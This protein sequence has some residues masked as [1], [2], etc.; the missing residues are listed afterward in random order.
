M[1]RRNVPKAWVPVFDKLEADIAKGVMSLLKD[2][3]LA[4]VLP[5]RYW[6]K[7]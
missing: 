2:L 6:L 3:K 7:H 5:E 4:L 1:R